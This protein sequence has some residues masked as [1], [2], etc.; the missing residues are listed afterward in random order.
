V[1][2]ED[3]KVF[4]RQSWLG[5]SLLCLERGRLMMTQPEFRTTNDSAMLGTAVH[6][7]IEAVLTNKIEARD[8]H[9]VSVAKLNELQLNDNVKITNTDPSTWEPLVTS[10]TKA[11]V[12]GVMPEVPLG[13][14]VEYKFAVPTGRM[15]SGLEL[16]FEGTMDY[17]HESGVWDWKTAARK[18][19]LLEKQT[20]NIQ[21]AIYSGASVNLGLCSH[22]MEGGIDFRFGVMVRSLKGDTQILSVRRGKAHW[23]WVVEQAATIV[24]AYLALREGEAFTNAMP[25]NDQHFLCSDRWCPWWS[26]CKG[27]FIQDKDNKLGD[28]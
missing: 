13:G 28:Q 14:E 10:M 24:G 25:K 12:D 22:D 18:Y 16:W 8:A 5:D 20:Q 11:W 9:H 15:V 7:G 17:V 3:G 21:S 26:V 27:V 23:D 2:I 4:V 6:A 1:R 19:S